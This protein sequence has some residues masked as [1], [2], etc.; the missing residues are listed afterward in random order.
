ME[1]YSLETG[2]KIDRVEGEW[3][4]Y[5]SEL[6]IENQ[7]M[8]QY[9]AGFLRAFDLT[10]GKTL[11]VRELGIERDWKG[12]T[13]G[14]CPMDIQGGVISI[15]A[16]DGFIYLVNAEDGSI[17]DRTGYGGVH[18]SS[19]AYIFGDRVIVHDSR[20]ISSMRPHTTWEK[21]NPFF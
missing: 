8:Y 20:R 16:D 17:R 9:W 10:T 5:H 7:Q 4:E 11:W 13:K 6:R 21:M 1:R 3:L 12:G 19:P 18:R 2:E 14:H 15:C